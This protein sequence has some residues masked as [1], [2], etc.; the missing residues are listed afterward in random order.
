MIRFCC[1]SGFHISSF[2]VGYFLFV[3][4][5][6]D[7]E[8]RRLWMMPNEAIRG[9]ACTRFLRIRS[10]VEITYIALSTTGSEDL[11]FHSFVLLLILSLS[12][13]TNKKLAIT[14]AAS[15]SR[16]TQSVTQVKWVKTRIS[17]FII[18]FI[19]EVFHQLRLK[20]WK[21]TFK[22]IEK[23]TFNYNV[24]TCQ[25]YQDVEVVIRF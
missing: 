25:G 12:N 18:T 21:F 8:V 10:Y 7:L 2:L 16:L 20:K 24:S 22:W 13:E 4:A 11:F 6:N 14:R 19:L 23:I 9:R 17:E 5:N 3:I 1:N 15:S